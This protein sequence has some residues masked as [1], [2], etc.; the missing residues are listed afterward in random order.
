M[1]TK[2]TTKERQTP[3]RPQKD[4]QSSEE[5]QAIL[6]QELQTLPA[7]YRTAIVLCDL[8]GKS[9]KQAAQQLGCPAGTVGARLV[10]GRSLL[11]RRLTRRQVT[12][13]SAGLAALLAQSTADAGV[14]P[15]LMHST[16]HAAASF[17]T[18]QVSVEGLF[19]AKVLSLSN[20]VMKAML[21]S[22][23]KLMG[24]SV[25]AVLLGAATLWGAAGDP[26][27]T[28]SGPSVANAPAKRLLI[29]AQPTKPVKAA[30]FIW[31]VAYTPDGNSLVVSEGE[32]LVR[33]WDMTT[34]L[35]GKSF[36]GAN[37]Y[38]RSVAVSPDGKL[39]AAGGDEGIVFVWEVATQKLLYQMDMPVLTE[40]EKAHILT[41]V[42]SPDGNTLACASHFG[43]DRS[44]VSLFQSKSGQRV[45]DFFCTEA[46]VPLGAGVALA[47]H[48][49]NKKIAL[50]QYGHFTGI[51]FLDSTNG[52]AINTI[53]YETGFIPES[54]A[55]SP[56]GLKIAT[57]G[58]A[59]PLPNPN[60][61]QL[62]GLPRGHVKIWDANKGDLLETLLDNSDGNV[63]TLAFTKNNKLIAGTTVKLGEPFQTKDGLVG[64]LGGMYVCWDTRE[65]AKL[66]SVRMR[67]GLTFGMSLSAD[68]RTL[69][70]ANSAGCSLIDLTDVGGANNKGIT[71]I[72]VT[73]ETPPS[74]P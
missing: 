62:F 67:G 17:A 15:L 31:A 24:V 6:D 50:L 30:N 7:I 9:I 12:L 48:P 10:R 60:N 36:T 1:N 56:D 59:P 22:K 8:E 11:A 64:I 49:Q 13:S 34:Q 25:G 44:S 70:I 45:W 46:A 63:K 14:P 65:W 61:A 69:A 73:P 21:L 71:Q 41:V 32:N 20:G 19:S 53:A 74:K 37:K 2:R 27:G 52:K 43:K 16:V 55:Y 29:Q 18:G 4:Q 39:L 3:P 47:F 26:G 33:L 58:T 38:I 68:D 28:T 35:P 72:A 23:L 51:R 57:G 40:K 66:W 5:L 42:F 54:I